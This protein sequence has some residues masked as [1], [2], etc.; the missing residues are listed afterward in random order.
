MNAMKREMR[1]RPK[2]ILINWRSETTRI[3]CDIGSIR[4][5]LKLKT[6]LGIQPRIMAKTEY[7]GSDDELVVGVATRRAWA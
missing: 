5:R 3:S 6:S 7:S 1:L 2:S 4:A